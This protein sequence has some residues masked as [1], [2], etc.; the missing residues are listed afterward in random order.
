MATNP[1]IQSQAKFRHM[2]DGTRAD[3]MIIA[4]E[5]AVHQ[6]AA[7]PMQI[8][9]TLR[10]LGDMVLGFAADQLTHSLMTGTLARRAGASD[11][12]VVAALCHDMGKIMSVPNHGQIAAEAL[13][14]YVSD[15]LYH[16]VY[17][18]QH[19]QGRYY[20][21]HMGKPTDLRLQFKD[22]PWYG[23]ACRLVDEWDAP[24]FDPGFDV[25]SLE[26]FEPEVVKVFSNPAAMI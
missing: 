14:P 13:K 7:A 16:A 19:F 17:W 24:A 12:E 1:E 26:S 4:R 18:H 20:Y 11:E 3:W 15:S 2:L 5:H 22:E 21:D 25:D 10:R 6:K 23:F 8:M 9:D